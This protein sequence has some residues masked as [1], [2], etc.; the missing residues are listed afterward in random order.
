MAGGFLR[1]G[2]KFGETSATQ[3]PFKSLLNP[4]T[5]EVRRVQRARA[6]GEGV[7]VGDFLGRGSYCIVTNK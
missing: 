4:P 5:N 6:E 7:F 2:K 1:D 3:F